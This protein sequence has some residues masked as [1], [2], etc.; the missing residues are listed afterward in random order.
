M[1]EKPWIPKYGDKYYM[2]MGIDDLFVCEFMWADSVSDIE[3]YYIGNCFTTR[4]EAESHKE[5]FIN[6]LKEVMGRY[7]NEN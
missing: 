4:E 6:K 1:E 3:S 5:E 2:F 7:R